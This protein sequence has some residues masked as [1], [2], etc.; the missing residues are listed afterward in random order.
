MV[1][2]KR[3]ARLRRDGTL[4]ANIYGRGLESIAV[5]L[6][7]RQA[8]EMLIAH[9]RDTLIEL[10]VAGE[11]KP[12]PVVV[13]SF[14]RHPVTR[15]VLHLD[16]FQVDL[17]RAIQ[18]TIP[19]HVTGEAPAVHTY[20]GVLL[21]GADSVQVESLPGD[22]PEALE[23][24]ID[25]LDELDTQVTVADL[26]AP[27]GVRIISDSEL[28]LARVARPR[29]VAAEEV[30]LLEGEEAPAVEGEAAAEAAEAEPAAEGSDG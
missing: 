13:R 9:G 17:N 2:G 22:L 8:R 23:V 6:P 12:R 4:P 1:V 21:H 16:F 19:V 27:A 25:G 28:M 24:S 10:Q 3:V 5:E 15:E 14:Q 29:L 7:A 30:E 26:V 11:S 18:A 20:Q